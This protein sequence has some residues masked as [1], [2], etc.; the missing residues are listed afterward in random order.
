MVLDI[1]FGLMV[2]LLVIAGGLTL[3]VAVATWLI[4]IG[5]IKEGVEDVLRRRHRE[6]AEERF[7]RLTKAVKEIERAKEGNT[8]YK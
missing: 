4:I 3:F 6:R 8:W 7:N 2:V 5:E 1:L